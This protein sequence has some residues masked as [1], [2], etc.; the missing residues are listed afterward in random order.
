MNPI[1]ISTASD[2][3]ECHSYTDHIPD[4]AEREL[5]RLHAGRYSS[6]AHFEVYGL[7]DQASTYV[8]RHANRTTALLLY[9]HDG[10]IVRVLNEGIPLTVDEAQRFA[11]H[12]FAHAPPP[13]A[14]L[15]R[16]VDMPPSAGQPLLQRG[17]CEQDSVLMLPASTDAYLDSLGART[18]S[19]LKNRLNKIRREH[20]SFTFQV[21][22]QG[23]IDPQHVR[24]IL[25]LHRQRLAG[26]RDAIAID[27][28]EEQRIRQM[29]ERCGLVGVVSI[30]GQCC[31]GSICYHNGGVVSAR[32]LA[33][34][35]RYDVYRLGFLCA[36]LMCSHCVERG[37]RQMN[38]GWGKEPYKFHLGAQ[39]RDL[40]D[41]I[42]YRNHAQRLRLAPLGLKLAW[43]AGQFQLRRLLS[44]LKA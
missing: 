34:D 28:G 42:I 31:A 26:R 20:P 43:R 32:F 35:T 16:A 2:R 4:Y 13:A 18:R 30:D 19:L 37:F 9:R 33:H 22:E 11:R 10:A 39:G 5:S 44:F 6:L 1:L 23:Q 38:F 36:Y 21:T 7:A 8:A 29:L 25:Q 41:V 40:S 24:A 15:L 17:I 12:V 3:V 14:V 27:S